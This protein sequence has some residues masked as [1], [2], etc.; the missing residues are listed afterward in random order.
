M[1]ESPGPT[2]VTGPLLSQ[3]PEPGD[4]ILLA[5]PRP[6]LLSPL[7]GAGGG[8]APQITR[9]ESGGVLGPGGSKDSLN[10]GDQVPPDPSL[11]FPDTLLPSLHLPD[12]ILI[13]GP[14][15]QLGPHTAEL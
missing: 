7:P 8:S 5:G 14:F 9:T 1:I 4:G 15:L 2:L 12:L 10:E 3:S 6:G 11:A 13:S